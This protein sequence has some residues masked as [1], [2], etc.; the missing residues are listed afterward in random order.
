V[1]HRRQFILGPAPVQPDLGWRCEELP[2]GL[3]LSVSPE[4]PIFAIEDGRGRPWRLLGRAVETRRGHPPPPAALSR[5]RDDDPSEIHRHLTG[6]WALVGGGCLHL[7]ACATLSGLYRRAGKSTWASSSPALINE[8]PGLD[9]AREIA[10]PLLGVGKGMDWYPPP[11][12]RFEGVF[13]LL[14]S[15]TL[16]LVSGKLAQR[17]IPAPLDPPLP[18]EEAIERAAEILT[19]AVTA[20]AFGRGD[21]WVPLTGGYDSRLALAAALAAGLE[22]RTYTFERPRMSTGD[23]KLPPLLAERVGLPHRFVRPRF[24]AN[25]ERQLSF[26]VHTARHTIEVDR[27]DYARGAWDVIPSEAVLLRGGVFEIARGFY[28]ER[29]PAELPPG[30]AGRRLLA[31]TFQFERFHRR[32]AAHRLGLERYLDWSNRNACPGL[33]WRDRLFMEQT[34]AGW[35]ASAAQGLD[36]FSPELAFPANSRE[37]LSMLLSIDPALRRQSKHHI[38]LIER[39]A[40]RLAGIPFNPP[41]RL[42]RQIA[43]VVRRELHDLAAYPGKG[44]YVAHRFRWVRSRVAGNRWARE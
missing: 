21:V 13:R 19:T 25:G 4:L 16:D 17:A 6:R 28:H 34:V 29:F 3:H 39:M 12:S 8:L 7:D 9:P 36:L 33:D 35:L 30:A 2:D 11:A 23:R 22:P 20:Y 42:P 43:D 32:S 40:P 10:P 37:L 26:D 24:P 5:L 18:Y 41:Q 38:D 31:Q 15:Q 27:D 1:L 14:P 44:R